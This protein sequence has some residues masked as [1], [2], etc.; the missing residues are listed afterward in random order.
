MRWLRTP[1]D[2][3]WEHQYLAGRGR[4]AKSRHPCTL[5]GN[6]IRGLSLAA[7]A[8][9]REVCERSGGC[10]SPVSSPRGSEC[11]CSGVSSVERR[12]CGVPEGV[13]S[14]TARLPTLGVPRIREI[15]ARGGRWS[16]CAAHPD[17][18]SGACA[19][20][21]TPGPSSGGVGTGCPRLG[22]GRP[23]R[24]TPRRPGDS[25]CGGESADGLATGLELV[26]ARKRRAVLEAAQ[27]QR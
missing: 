27:G 22:K 11:D 21:A 26:D 15:P 8:G 3:E 25:G 24:R 9:S 1:G 23:I 17:S 7:R 18:A 10:A 20:G 12:L 19:R 14:A 5:G 6:P 4:Q 16:G 2:A 13:R